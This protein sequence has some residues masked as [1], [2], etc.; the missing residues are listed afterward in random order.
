M[1]VSSKMGSNEMRASE[2]HQWVCTVSGIFQMSDHWNSHIGLL[3]YCIY[4]FVL[5]IQ[6]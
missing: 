2:T 6:H 4:V 1:W 5:Q 3:P